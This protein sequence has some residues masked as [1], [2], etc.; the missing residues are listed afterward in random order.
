MI[1]ALFLWKRQNQITH[2]IYQESIATI[3]KLCKQNSVQCQPG[4]QDRLAQNYS[5]LHSRT[6]H[7]QCLYELVCIH[8]G[9]FGN[10][11]YDSDTY[12]GHHLDGRHLELSRIDASF[13]L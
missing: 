7:E 13:I 12:E 10:H 9:H 1:S 6:I 5:T 3:I 11:E 4:L 2:H 8:G